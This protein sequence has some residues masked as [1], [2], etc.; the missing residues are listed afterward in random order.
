MIGSVELE[1]V[2]RIL[3][4]MINFLLFSILAVLRV[5]QVRV[6]SIF[7]LSG[8]RIGFDLDYL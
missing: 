3:V 5:F 1:T 7:N 4:C 2:N 8:L 6:N